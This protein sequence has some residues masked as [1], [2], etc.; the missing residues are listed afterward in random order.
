M[1]N[2]FRQGVSV[3][4]PL[5]VFCCKVRSGQVVEWRGIRGIWFVG[6]VCVG[7]AY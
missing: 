4:I 5:E 7:W 6:L 1:E 2:H 3:C